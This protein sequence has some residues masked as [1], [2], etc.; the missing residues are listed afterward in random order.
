M[1]E[2]EISWGHEIDGWPGAKFIFF[3]MNLESRLIIDL[4]WTDPLPKM[5]GLFFHL[6]FYLTRAYQLKHV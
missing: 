3:S 4:Q 2:R 6:V 5:G 1:K